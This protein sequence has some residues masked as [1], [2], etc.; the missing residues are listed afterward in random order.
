MKKLAFLILPIA[1]LSACAPHT[2]AKKI[3]T[4][5]FKIAGGTVDM[6][7]TSQ[8]EADYNR[9]K[10]MRKQEERDAKERKAIEKQARKIAKEYERD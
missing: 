2:V 1:A 4:A 5:P 6:L 3:V 9:G 10:K 8:K 7:T